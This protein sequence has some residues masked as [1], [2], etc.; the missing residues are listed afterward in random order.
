[1]GRNLSEEEYLWCFP[2]VS[3]PPTS[4]ATRGSWIYRILADTFVPQVF[5]PP[6]PDHAATSKLPQHGFARISRWEFLGKSTSESSASTSKDGGDSS[7]K[8]DFGLSPSNL[9]EETKALWPFEFG[10]I[11]SVTLGKDSL[12]TTLVVRNEGE[13]AWEF[14]TLLHTYFKIKVISSPPSKDD[15]NTPLQDISSLSVTGLEKSEY[16]DKVSVPISTKESPA[17]PVTISGRT[18]RVYDPKGEPSDPVTILEG[19]KKKFSIVRDNM[20]Q[21]VVW[22]PWT[23]C[24]S[25]GDFAPATGYKEMICVEAGAVKDWQRLEAGETWEGGQIITAAN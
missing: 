7:V 3:Q 22:N 12:I 2:C 15:A 8:L 25:M 6:A 16:I 9:S 24:T 11:Y 10:L 20:G 13:E 1:M 18:D 23:E 19:G 5:G 4:A 14:K 21:V 17:G